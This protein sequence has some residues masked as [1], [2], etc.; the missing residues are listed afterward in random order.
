MEELIDLG[1]SVSELKEMIEKEPLLENV[2]LEMLRDKINLLN[3]FN[4][5]FYYH[6]K[7]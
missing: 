1:I 3:E 2:S 4:F 5:I 7:Y 6:N